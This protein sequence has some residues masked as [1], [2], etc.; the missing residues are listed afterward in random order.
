MNPHSSSIANAS[1]RGRSLRIAAIIAF[2]LCLAQ[3]LYA[4]STSLG[5]SS[6][7]AAT[8]QPTIA[9]DPFWPIGYRPKTKEPVAVPVPTPTQLTRT[10]TPIVPAVPVVKREPHW[11]ELRLSGIVKNAQGGYIAMV[12]PFGMVQ[13]GQI[14]ELKRDGF[15]YRWKVS[16]ITEKGATCSRLDAKAQ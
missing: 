5:S 16:A 14:L 1:A 11:P 8:G 15:V 10:P 12:E 7:S 9:R 2:V 6:S 4:Q 13:L 3:A